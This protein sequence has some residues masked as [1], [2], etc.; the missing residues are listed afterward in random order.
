[1]KKI[2]FILTLFA[3]LPAISQMEDVPNC[4]DSPM[5][6]RL[7]YEYIQDCSKNFN[8]LEVPLGMEEDGATKFETKEGTLTFVEYVYFNES[9]DEGP[10]FLQ[11][12]K[13][14]ENAM[15]KTGGK[16]VFYSAEGGWATLHSK[17]GNN[18]IW[19]VLQD[20]SGTATGNYQ[21]RILE[22]EGMTQEISAD[23]MLTG[24]NTNGFISLYI[25]FETG[26][27]EILAESQASIDQI[28]VLMKS[29]P[30]LRI[31]IEGHTDGD[32]TPESNQELSEK[33]AAAIMN[34]IIAQGIDSSRLTSKGWGQTKPIGDN[35]TTDGKASNRRVEIVKI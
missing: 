12:V 24:L 20:F 29:N 23:E 21:L 27:S 8:Q 6:N 4:K 18:E 9:G 32:G 13:N 35:R 11:I 16:R 2:V 3:A 22:I 30:D 25:N 7:P 15:L 34:A 17:S 19:V 26:K 33:R 28:V 14:Y 31:S 1:M 5:F 10:S